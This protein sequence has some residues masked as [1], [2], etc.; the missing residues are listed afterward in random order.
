MAE[1]VADATITVGQLVVV[2]GQAPNS[3]YGAVF[4]DDGITGYF[5]GL[6]FSQQEQPI[7]D[8]RQIYNVDQVT[9][10]SIPSVVQIAFSADGLK[11]ALIIN[12]YPHAIIDFAARR[13]YC[14]TGFPRPSDKWSAHG[15]EWDDSAVE[16]LR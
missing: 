9:D 13:S 14:R 10:R 2:E 5:Y 7:V 12:K 8:A 11:A 1:L 3:H 6:D 16:L 4:E 15:A